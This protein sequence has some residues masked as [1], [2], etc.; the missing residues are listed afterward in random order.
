MLYLLII[1][2]I[3][4]RTTAA[5][6]EAGV[7]TWGLWSGARYDHGGCFISQTKQLH[8]ST[9]LGT[10]ELPGR[11]RHFSLYFLERARLMLTHYAGSSCILSV[12]LWGYLPACR[13]WKA[14][15]CLAGGAWRKTR[16]WCPECQRVKGVLPH[17]VNIIGKL[18]LVTSFWKDSDCL[19]RMVLLYLQ[20]FSLFILRHVSIPF[21]HFLFSWSTFWPPKNPLCHL[22]RL[23][24]CLVLCRNTGTKTNHSQ[25][26]R[27]L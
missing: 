8:S 21:Y 4:V 18:E 7:S 20:A 9:C 17:T 5:S 3:I 13:V 1:E 11:M 10:T 19:V 6:S 27:K 14:G 26:H 25:W 16:L 2:T 22:W 15:K 12:H 24:E 23:N